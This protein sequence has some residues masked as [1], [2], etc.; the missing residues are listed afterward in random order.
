ME[1]TAVESLLDAARASLATGM[2]LH[3]SKVQDVIV[4]CLDYAGLTADVTLVPDYILDGKAVPEDK[5]EEVRSYEASVAQSEA[6]Q[7]AVQPEEDV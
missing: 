1:S 7:A 3:W 2:T 6:S 4:L 5:L